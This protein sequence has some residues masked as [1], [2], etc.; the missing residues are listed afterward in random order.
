[1]ADCCTITRSSCT[2]TVVQPPTGSETIVV[3]QP[4]V[5]GFIVSSTRSATRTGDV[6][7]RQTI[8]QLTFTVESTSSRTGATSMQLVKGDQL[9]VANTTSSTHCGDAAIDNVARVL[10]VESTASTTMAGT[11]QLGIHPDF[12][13]RG[14]RSTTHATDTT[15]DQP[16]KVFTPDNTTSTT[17]A[18]DSTL[19]E[20]G[21]FSP[22]D[23]V[24]S[25]HVTDITVI[26]KHIFTV[27]VTSS[28]TRSTDTTLGAGL[29]TAAVYRTTAGTVTRTGT[30]I[31]YR[32]SDG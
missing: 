12:L 13:V 28:A 31:K 27:Q 32:S 8:T 10:T 23:A 18:T 22:N 4:D 30:G 15:L 26:Q 2:Q 29:I 17:R 3:C 7:L 25:T 14:N 5:D 19:I 1:M 20:G 9:A 21:T 6:Q 24:S 16:H 11:T